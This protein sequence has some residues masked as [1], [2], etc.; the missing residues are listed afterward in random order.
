MP[1]VD[2]LFERFRAAYRAGETADPRPF[3]DELSGAERREL[4]VLVDAF[5]AHAP[6]DPYD[7]AAF[8]EFRGDPW[9]ERLRRRVDDRLA[10]SE[11]S[12]STL[13]PRARTAAR[14]KRATVVSRLA[15]ALGVGE[16]EQKV[17]G[18]YHRMETGT[19]P[20]PGVSTRVL[21]ALSDILGISVERLRAA[22]QRVAPPPPASPGTLF[23]RT[24][25]APPAAAPAA[26]AA[27]PEEWDE[28]DELFR[29]GG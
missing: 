1:T 28:V 12:W 9:T 14:L 2:E 17:A 18:Y 8:A 15:A 11:E 21:E 29:G 25:A 16:R 19:L 13:L 7:P 22:G 3:L 10:E 5:L 6:R 27:A 24:A 20:A 26:R 4:A 23:A